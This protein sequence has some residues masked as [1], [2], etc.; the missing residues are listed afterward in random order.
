[1]TAADSSDSMRSTPSAVGPVTY[2]NAQV[3]RIRELYE[4]GRGLQEIG[5]MFNRN[6]STVFRVLRRLGVQFRKSAGEG[7]HPSQVKILDFVESYR[8]EHG[9][10]P[11]VRELVAATG[12]RSTS[13][14]AHHV[15]HLIS[16]GRLRRT[17]GVARG[18][19]VVQDNG[20]A[21]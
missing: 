9:F 14:V 8:N 20:E 10:P 3:H 1:M 15:D 4:S 13:S 7:L 11:S 6:P 21:S 5:L 18:L 19:V 17:P 12:L 2:G 16:I